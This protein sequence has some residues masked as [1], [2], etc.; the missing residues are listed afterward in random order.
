MVLRSNK[1]EDVNFDDAVFQGRVGTQCISEVKSN[2]IN[3]V[4][5]VGQKNIGVLK[6]NHEPHPNQY[7]LCRNGTWHS[8]ELV[9]K[10][11]QLPYFV[12]RCKS[13]EKKNA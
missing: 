8:V 3:Y 2:I 4:F 7:T 12:G 1:R 9:E 13:V 6:T 11:I 5:F 10:A